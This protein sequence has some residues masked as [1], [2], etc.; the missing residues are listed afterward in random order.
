MSTLIFESMEVSRIRRRDV[1]ICEAV[2]RE[3]LVQDEAE[4]PEVEVMGGIW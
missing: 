1:K 2:G 3:A 4:K